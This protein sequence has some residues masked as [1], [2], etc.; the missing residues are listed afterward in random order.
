MGN[1]EVWPFLFLIGMLFFNWPFLDLFGSHLPYYLF[2]TWAL[3]I[4]LIG[5]FISVGN[6][7]GK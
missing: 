4:L 2:A 7:Q 6:K 3:F 5:I 1:K